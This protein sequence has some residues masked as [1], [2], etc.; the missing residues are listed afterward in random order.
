M[1]F[2]IGQGERVVALGEPEQRHCPKCGQL[3]AFQKQLRYKYGSFDM[4]FGFAYDKRYQLACLQCNHGW[5]LDARTTE[6]ELG[7][8]PIP[9]HLRYGL[10]V[11]A[12][13]AALLGA[14]AMAV[15]GLL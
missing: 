15:N 8:V 3:T 14:S 6:R 10:C 9:F 4:L 13:L 2:L 11:L 12:V 5:I 7:R 1:M